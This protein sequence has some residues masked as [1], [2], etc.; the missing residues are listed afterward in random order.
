MPPHLQEHPG[1]APSQP[2][3]QVQPDSVP[4]LRDPGVRG[5]G[6]AHQTL[7]HLP[8]HC[9]QVPLHIQLEGPL[10]YI[11]GIWISLTDYFIII[12]SSA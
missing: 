8:A 3:E 2:P 11:P 7:Q 6:T 12:S 10:Q 4:L 5:V 9:H 1:P